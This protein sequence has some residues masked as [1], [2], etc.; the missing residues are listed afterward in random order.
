MGKTTTSWIANGKADSDLG[1]IRTALLKLTYLPPHANDIYPVM[2]RYFWEFNDN[3][4]GGSGNHNG[5]CFV[6]PGTQQ[7]P[8]SSPYT[9]AP[10]YPT[11][12]KAAWIQVRAKL[13]GSIIP[14]PNITFVWNPDMWDDGLGGNDPTNYYPGS[15]YV[16]WIGIDGYGKVENSAPLTFDQV[17]GSF[18]AWA[19]NNVSTLG[20]KP[21]MIG[22]TASCAEYAP[23]SDQAS[24][25]QGAQHVLDDA[26][27]YPAYSNVHA[28]LY[29]DAPGGYTY[30]NPQ[31]KCHW[32]LDANPQPPATGGLSQ[33]TTMGMDSNFAPIALPSP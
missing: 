31:V 11:Q 19:N 6:T 24:Y 1:D 10:D 33:F 16:D 8:G 2:L 4:G 30:G 9:I 23:P 12:F 20:Q 5:G 18:M 7:P 17:F 32:S 28:F 25:L 26:T 29:F 15:A 27:D 21:I 13:L 3:I 22:E 14:V